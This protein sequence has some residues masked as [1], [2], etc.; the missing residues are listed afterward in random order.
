MSVVDLVPEGASP[1]PEP[2]PRDYGGTRTVGDKFAIEGDVK[3]RARI[4][5]CRQGMIQLEALRSKHHRLMQEMRGRLPPIPGCADVQTRIKKTTAVCL[6][7]TSLQSV[8]SGVSSMSQEYTI[9]GYLDN[10][11][12]TLLISF[13]QSSIICQLRQ[14]LLQLQVCDQKEWLEH[15]ESN[16][17]D[18]EV[19]MTETPIKKNISLMLHKTHQ[20]S[21]VVLLSLLSYQGDPHY[22]Y[23]FQ[24][25]SLHLKVLNINAQCYR[26]V[27]TIST[28]H[29]VRATKGRVFERVWKESEGL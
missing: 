24:L 22:C 21:F 5:A 25:F 20:Q 23:L 7:R 26:I 19:C 15:G 16:S 2:P 14:Q 3:I 17:K 6:D 28:D 10:S 1:P 29:V 13:G 27:P 4:E 8:D 18:Q 12:N 9:L 11:I